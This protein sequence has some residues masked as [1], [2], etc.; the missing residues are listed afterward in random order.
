MSLTPSVPFI[1]CVFVNASR[2]PIH[3]KSFNT[4]QISEGYVF[5]ECHEECILKGVFWKD[6]REGDDSDG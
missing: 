3:R 4:A 5:E 2:I 1:R 6:S